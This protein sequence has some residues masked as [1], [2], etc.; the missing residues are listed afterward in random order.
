MFNIIQ[1]NEPLIKNITTKLCKKNPDYTY[2]EIYNMVMT[3]LWESYKKN[4]KINFF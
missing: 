2:T 3:S 4:K 1:E